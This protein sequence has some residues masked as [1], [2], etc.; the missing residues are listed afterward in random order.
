MKWVEQAG[1]VK[2]DFLG[3]KTLS[4]L[5]TAVEL[6]EAAR[7]RDRSARH[8]ARRRKELRDARARRDGRHLSRWK[9]RACVAP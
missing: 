9:G 4:V 1:L 6:A 8:P 5:Q 2:F 3:L 7:R